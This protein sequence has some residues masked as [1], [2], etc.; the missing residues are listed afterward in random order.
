MERPVGTCAFPDLGWKTPLKLYLSDGFDPP[1]PRDK[2][3]LREVLLVL[4]FVLSGVHTEGL[5]CKMLKA[6]LKFHFWAEDE[7]LKQFWK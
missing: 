5:F 2:D 4:L 7:G 3:K 1:R 6:L